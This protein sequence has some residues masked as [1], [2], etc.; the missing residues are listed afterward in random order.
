MDVCVCIAIDC[1]HSNI[2]FAFL[3]DE[4]VGLPS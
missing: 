1:N 2:L 3:I 4:Y